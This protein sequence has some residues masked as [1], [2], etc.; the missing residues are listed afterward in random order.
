MKTMNPLDNMA[1]T[2]GAIGVIIGIA[3]LKLPY[4]SSTGS[5]PEEAKNLR[6][7]FAITLG[8]AGLIMFLNGLYINF[9]GALGTFSNHWPILFGGLPT[10]GGLIVMASAAALY[11]NVS[12]SIVTYFA[13]IIGVF[14]A[15]DAYAI[16]DY[17]LTKNP[18]LA[19][20]GF[21]SVAGALWGSVLGANSDNKALRYLFAIL[22]FLFAIA[23][24]YQG[25]SFT[26]EHLNPA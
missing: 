14:A 11:F 17:G 2:A 4:R 10:L 13:G 26:L 22:A 12:Q 19:S 6:M 18:T 7:S 24:L 1:W 3:A 16:I 9:T 15:V 8:A 5:V 23:W 21:L 20:L 25:F